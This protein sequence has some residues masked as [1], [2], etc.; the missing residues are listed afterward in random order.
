MDEQGRKRQM[1]S[2]DWTAVALGMAIGAVFFAGLAWGMRIALRSARP[3]ALLALSAAIRMSVLLGVGWLVVGQ[4]GPWSLLG[5][6]AAFL[7]VRFIA[8]TI[9]SVAP[10]SGGAK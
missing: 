10:A 3:V 7:M 6:A 8:T 2:F 4:G 9:M 1:I 5:Y